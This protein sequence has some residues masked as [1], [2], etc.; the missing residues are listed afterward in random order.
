MNC[1]FEMGVGMIYELGSLV[2]HYVNGDRKHDSPTDLQSL[3]KMGVTSL[4]SLSIM[5]RM[6]GLLLEG[7]RPVTRAMCDQRRLGMTRG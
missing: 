6:T 2:G 4:D 7:G 3:W 5:V 1:L